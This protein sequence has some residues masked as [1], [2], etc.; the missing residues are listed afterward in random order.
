MNIKLV[1]IDLD[2]TLL[3]DDLTISP[4]AKNAIRRAMDQGVQVTLATGRMYRSALPYAQEL[5]V[6]VP[7]ITYQGG[8]VKLS[9]TGEVLYHRELPLFYAREI[10]KKARG[11][12]FQINSYVNDNLYVEEDTHLSRDYGKK[13]GVKVHVVDDLLDFLTTEPTKLLLI[14]REEE[15]DVMQQE[16]RQLFGDA[17]YI[18]KSKY[19][20]LEFTHPEATKGHGLMAVARWM[21]VSTDDIMAIGDSYNDLE[22]FCHAG[23]SVVMG[24]ARDEVKAAADYVTAT[25][26]DD[27]VA[28]AIEK[29]VL[30]GR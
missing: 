3:G 18:T 26:E 15:L 29:F 4:R 14:G 25:C 5:G 21:G 1:A 10:I 12:G 19:Y 28:E 16:C 13:T 6:E 11:Y 23:L 17:V 22:M 27:G 2:G 9:K 7:L 30:E 24:N 8:L 20:F